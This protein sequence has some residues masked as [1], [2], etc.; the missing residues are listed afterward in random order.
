MDEPQEQA[1]SEEIQHTSGVP[2]QSMDDF[3][4][5]GDSEE[6]V[7]A[8]GAAARRA[9]QPPTKKQKKSVDTEA[10]AAEAEAV[11]VMG[12]TNWIGKLNGNYQ[13]TR[14]LWI[15]NLILW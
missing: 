10:L 2:L 8:S 15:L 9:D 7:T 1:V 12:D 13:N 3:M 5:E 11:K 14:L 6:L 4:K